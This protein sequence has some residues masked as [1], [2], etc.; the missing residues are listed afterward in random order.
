MDN[1]WI[2]GKN[3]EYYA[4]L[5][6]LR[7]GVEVIDRETSPQEVAFHILVSWNS[8][9]IQD[10]TDLKYEMQKLKESKNDE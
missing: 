9:M 6:A 8:R 5:D 1:I 2:G 10:C 3:E 4:F 7:D